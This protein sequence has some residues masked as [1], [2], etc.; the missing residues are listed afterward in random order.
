[1]DKYIGQMQMEENLPAALLTSMVEAKEKQQSDMMDIKQ[2]LMEQTANEPMD[3]FDRGIFASLMPETQQE[4]EGVM[5]ADEVY[6]RA[7]EMRAEQSTAQPEMVPMGGE[8]PGGDVPMDEP[9]APPEDIP[10]E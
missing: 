4:L 5:A 1:M 6:Q 2:K 9:P 8:I 10:E 3:A 7:L